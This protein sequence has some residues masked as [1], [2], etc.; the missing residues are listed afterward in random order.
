MTTVLLGMNN[1]DPDDAFAPYKKGSS[2]HRLV[3]M[4][5]EYL[6]SEDI[7]AKCN[8]ELFMRV[9]KRVNMLN[10]FDWN[11]DR[12]IARRQEVLTDIYQ[13]KIVIFGDQT[14][15]ALGFP[16]AKYCV[17]SSFAGSR[18]VSLPHPSGLT[19][20]FNN[21][22]LRLAAGEILF[23]ELLSGI[24]DLWKEPTC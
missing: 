13:H 16:K 23:N 12:A 6:A 11:L 14:H 17:W 19:R 2:G 10:E 1:P 9:F 5:D 8:P 18:Y 15:R 7:D 22:K 21:H 3:K 4:I 20:A 24:L